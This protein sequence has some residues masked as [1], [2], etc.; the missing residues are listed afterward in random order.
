LLQI[1]QLGEIQVA[2]LGLQVD[3]QRR[4][5]VFVGQPL[6]GDLPQPLGQRRQFAILYR[7]ARGRGVAAM[8]HQQ[9]LLR[10]AIQRGRDVEF[11][12]AARAAAALLRPNSIT[13]A[14]R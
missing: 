4:A 1:A 9:I 14:G 12:D 13:M 3:Q 8:A 11:G 10:A 5:Q 6:G 2:H 7:Q